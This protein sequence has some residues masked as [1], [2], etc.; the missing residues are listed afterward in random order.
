MH[1]LN[2]LHQ[3]EHNDE[4]GDVEQQVADGDPV[5]E[6]GPVI[7]E[8]DPEILDTAANGDHHPG[9]QEAVVP[10]LGPEYQH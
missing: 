5:L 9:D 7:P 2:L 8:D 10:H 4:D 1:I 3:G 6:A